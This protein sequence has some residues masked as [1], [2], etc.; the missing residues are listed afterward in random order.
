MT[1]R[2]GEPAFEDPVLIKADGL[3]T[4]HLANVVDDHLMKIT[5][6]VRGIEWLP[7]TPKH[8]FMYSAFNWK[9]PIFCHVGLLQDPSGQKLS[10]RSGDV[11]VSEYRDKGYH[12]EALL[13]FVALLGWH[14]Q[15]RK[16]FLPL[17]ELE[18]RVS[19]LFVFHQYRNLIDNITTVRPQGVDKR[20]Y[21]S[22]IQ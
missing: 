21:Q 16:D 1:V 13:N 4:Y 2:H 3:P 18:K 15:L 20:Q 22:L 10:K 5:H 7:S 19:S 12:P 6:V 9:P 8:V 11:H 14:N 17:K